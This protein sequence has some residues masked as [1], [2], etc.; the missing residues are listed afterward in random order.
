VSPG[1]LCETG[2]ES[3]S[4]L[5]KG[6]FPITGWHYKK[7]RPARQAISRSTLQPWGA[8]NQVFEKPWVTS[9]NI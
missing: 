1:K 2:M 9:I 5:T 7:T 8:L 6:P 4:L 3:D